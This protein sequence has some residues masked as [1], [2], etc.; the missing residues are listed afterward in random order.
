MRIGSIF[1][2]LSASLVP[3]C[4]NV[5]CGDGTIERNGKCAPADVTTSTA[6]CGPDTMLEGDQCL[7]SIVC[8]PQTTTAE[9]DPATGITVCVGTGGTPG[10][11]QPISCPPGSS[12]SKQ[13]ICG[14]IYDLENN[15]PF[16]DT[17]ALGSPCPPTPTAT[18]PCALAIT[19]YDALQFAMS[20]STATPL[21]VANT[22]IDDC[23]RF[24]L[25][26][27]SLPGSPFIGLG[28][29][30]AMAADQGP[31]GVTNAVGIALPKL[32]G[33]ATKG[34]E[35]WIAK[36]STTSAWESSGGPPVSSGVYVGIFRQHCVAAGCT[37]DPFAPQPDVTFTKS[38]ATIPNQDYYFMA[39]Q[40]TR[41]TIDPSATV[42]GANGTG[43]LDNVSISDMFVYSGTGGITDVVDCKWE[44]HAA[45]ALPN[46]VFVQLFRKQNQ[47]GKTCAE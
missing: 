10:C 18:G 42:T 24:R 26:D 32:G 1:L 12:S 36:A 11:G 33:S 23:G 43:I 6:T 8:D 19:A 16:A 34:V 35:H 38:G 22:Y 39:G 47:L 9:V 28:I 37:G 44:T 40:T 30:D 14:Q 27:V 13:T 5:E 15:Q 21:T 4:K 46:I 20:P 17:G 7:S 2:V 41:M 29:D 45:A 25:T 31:A 3:A